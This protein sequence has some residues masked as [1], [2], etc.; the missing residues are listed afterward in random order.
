MGQRHIFWSMQCKPGGLSWPNV[1]FVVILL[2]GSQVSAQPSGYLWFMQGQRQQGM[3]HTGTGISLG[4][5]STYMNPAGMVYMP[6][7]AEMQFG[8]T[9]LQPRTRFKS[10]RGNA[11]VDTTLRQVSTPV[12]AYAAWKSKKILFGRRVAFGVSANNP[13]GTS[14]QWPQGWRGKFIVETLGISSLVVQ[15]ALALQLD[16]NLSIG[17]GLGYV[18]ATLA[19][20]QALPL[21]GIND[22]ESVAEFVGGGNGWAINTGL[23]YQADEHLSLGANFRLPYQL[24]INGDARYQVPESLVEDYPEGTWTSLL[25]IPAMFSLGMGYKTDDRLV[26]ALDLNVMRWERV[27]SLKINLEEVPEGLQQ[28]PI[29]GLE[30]SFSLRGGL[31]YV[32]NETV[33]LRGG[34]AYT[35]SPVDRNN[36]SPALPDADQISFSV[37][38]TLLFLRQL[39]LDAGVTYGFTG[40]RTG[41]LN[42]ANFAGTYQ[43]R[44]WQAGVG[45]RYTFL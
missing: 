6:R 22:A 28:F 32:Y 10:S 34:L 31:E 5:A 41:I 14:I 3:A 30:N 8:T 4:A 12:Y 16:D 2:M 33:S 45:L 23:Y 25:G 40:E 19:K 21:D 24:N 11:S 44:T 43:T 9:L 15:P 42:S 27:D 36:L 20:R 17:V 7:R 39:S 18:S 35:S 29:M 37:G 13:Y 1:L 26:V 38:G